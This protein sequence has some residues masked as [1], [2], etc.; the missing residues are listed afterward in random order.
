[1]HLVLNRHE[2]AGVATTAASPPRI[3]VIIPVRNDPKR[4]AKCLESL[5]ASTF[6][7]YEVIVADDG[8]TDETPRVAENMGARLVQL[9]RQR[10]AAAA[11]N[12]AAAVA[13]GTILMFIDADVCVH[14]ET[15]GIAD[16]SFGD[17]GIDAVF[18]SYDLEPGEPNLLSQYKNLAHRFYHQ[19]NSRPQ[20]STFWTGCGAIRRDVF[21]AFRFDAEQFTRPSIEDIELGARLTRAGKRIVINKQ[22]QA[23]HLKRWTLLG[24]I[25]SDLFDRAIPWTRVILRDKSLP[26]D[27]NL[28]AGQ[29]IAALLSALSAAIFLI[30]CWFRPWLVLL[31]LGIAA[32]IALGDQLTSRGKLASIGRALVGAVI[33]TGAAA[34]AYYARWWSA[35]IL[36]PLLGVVLINSKFYGF[37][38]RHRG[39]LFVAAALPMHIAYYLYSIV[40]F[41][42]GTALH[43]WDTLG[44]RLDS[45]RERVR[46]YVALS[47][48]L[49]ATAWALVLIRARVKHTTA[50]F[51]V[52]DAIGYYAYL[53]SIV[54]DHD[55]QFD[56][57]LRDRFAPD[58]EAE[59]RHAL[60][61]NRWPSGMALSI[62]PAFLFAHGT[63][64]LLYLRTGWAAIKPD[65]YTVLYQFC[66]VAWAMAIGVLGMIIAD[67]FLIERVAVRGRIAAAAI[68]TT[69]LGTNY[70]WYFVREPLLAHMIGASWVIFSVYLI[71]RIELNSRDGRLVWWHLPLLAFTASMALICRMTNAFMMPMFVYLLVVLVRRG[72]L[73]RVLK[74]TPLIIPAL[75]PLA[76][77]A[78]LFKLMMGHSS[79]DSVQSL[80]YGSNERF[81][82][83]HPALLR[84]LF[85]SRH[86]LFFGTPAILLAAWGLLRYLLRRDGLKARDPLI[87]C[88]IVSAVLLW[89]VNAAW[90]AWWFGPS[91][92]NR[93]FVELAGLY[94]I[95]FALLYKWLITVRPRQRQL[96][97]AAL[98]LCFFVNYGIMAIKALDIVG[99]HDSLIRWED[100]V[101]TG[102]WNRI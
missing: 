19:Q 17:P 96:V 60:R 72:M 15:L 46:I 43:W 70:A 23:K 59:F 52:S 16:S 79:P 99:E 32:S 31:P 74:W 22:L 101:L 9:P 25:R 83:T 69:W 20:V 61:H 97:L 24:I 6:T 85:S 94:A 47:L 4:L 93:G 11:R 63:S 84:T 86:G 102:P 62:A 7:D 53:P 10:G 58:E 80:G 48:V 73:V 91:V 89:Y 14:P 45:T 67:R 8:S 5:A 28:S 95:G 90:Y 3:S 71:H 30:S 77:Q 1:M 44:E 12:S 29:R 54:L 27:L 78:M 66:C 34:A 13:R 37:F 50:D 35:A 40:G 2:K 26:G 64:L 42:A 51:V 55:L 88:F 98:G 57:Q 21:N 92:G 39:P 49:F 76:L 41:A 100:R 56:N 75:A 81:Y 18:G 33:L 87:V 38:L 65:G 82:W 68:L 36:L